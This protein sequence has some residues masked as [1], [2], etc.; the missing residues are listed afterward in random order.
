MTAQQHSEGVW[1]QLVDK[2]KQPGFPES[3]CES[4]SVA[5]EAPRELRAIHDHE[6]GGESYDSKHA[7]ECLGRGRAQ[8]VTRTMSIEHHLR[9]MSKGKVSV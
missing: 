5:R 1:R 4:V 2:G 9:R 7:A 8:Q 6:V 3:D